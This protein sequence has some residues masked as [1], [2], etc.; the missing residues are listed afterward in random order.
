MA[1]MAYAAVAAAALSGCQGTHGSRTSAPTGPPTAAR[2]STSPSVSQSTSE[3][4]M[5]AT[6]TVTASH[7]SEISIGAPG[8]AAP[9]GSVTVSC[10]D[11]ATLRVHVTGDPDRTV[12]C[13]GSTSWHERQ[14]ARFFT[15]YTSGAQPVAV[16]VAWSITM[17]TSA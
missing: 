7:P 5:S 16:A 15:A 17:S 10:T 3:L 9:G 11:Q 1:V 12:S 4:T 13:P 8:I 2:P 14:G 6:G